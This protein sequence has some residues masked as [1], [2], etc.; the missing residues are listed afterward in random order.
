M[1][2]PSRRWAA[3]AP[4]SS[5]SFL[6]AFIS[7]IGSVPASGVPPASRIR[8]ASADAAVVASSLTFAP[9][10]PSAASCVVRA[11]GGAISPTAP[12]ASPAS[13]VIFSGARKTVG[14]PS[15]GTM[16]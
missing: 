8:L 12:I 2:A 3:R 7:A 9:A 1:A 14:R 4:A 5:A 10:A 16:A 6:R 15:R 11:A 13:L